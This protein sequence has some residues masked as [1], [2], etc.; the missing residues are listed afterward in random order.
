MCRADHPAVDAKPESLLDL[1]PYRV[2]GGDLPDSY[3]APFAALEAALGLTPEQSRDG[4]VTSENMQLITNLVFTAEVIAIIPAMQASYVLRDGEVVQLPIKELQ[5][6]K[7]LP[8]CVAWRADRSA[9][10]AAE[11]L[12]AALRECFKRINEEK[13]PWQGLYDRPSQR[14]AAKQAQASA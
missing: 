9:A 8:A 13:Q 7:R 12:R 11:V 6:S 10:P 2:V 4:Y 5:S 14:A 3:H 1:A